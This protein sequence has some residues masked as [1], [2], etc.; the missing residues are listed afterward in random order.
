MAMGRARRAKGKNQT[1]LA[2]R[3]ECSKS[4]I[5]CVESGERKLQRIDAEAADNALEQGGALLRLHDELYETQ[6]LD[7]QDHLHQLQS[8]AE[9]IREYQNTLVP[10]LLQC[11]DYAKEVIAAGGPW[12]LQEEIDKRA[13]ERMERSRRILESSLPHLY[14]VLDDLVIK[15]PSVGAEVM[16]QQCRHL[17]DL[18]DS[19]R[20]NLQFFPWDSRPHA[21]LNGPLA[22]IASEAAPEVFHAESVYLGQSF[23]D[24]ATVR[25][26][27]MLFAKLQANARTEADSRR[28][29]HEVMK[30][31]ADA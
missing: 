8:Q 18:V 25:R 13:G 17:L 3:L 23:Y 9:V 10:G 26:Y 20:V 30:E 16:V 31:Y 2:S 29:L 12:L 1:W 21:G 4:H 5:S 6:T 11:E 27:G 24:T 22:L 19:R 28:F 15:R 7:W 14:V